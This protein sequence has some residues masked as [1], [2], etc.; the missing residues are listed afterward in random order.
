MKRFFAILLS[1]AMLISASLFV[2]CGDNDSSSGGDNY[3]TGG[4]NGDSSS[5]SSNT[6]TTTLSA[7]TGLTATAAS[8]SQVN[9]YWNSVTDATRYFLYRSEY[10]LS[11]TAS[12]DTVETSSPTTARGLKANTKYYF[13]VQAANDITK[14]EYSSY[15]YATTWAT[16]SSG[17]SGTTTTKLS[18]PTGVNAYY[19]YENGSVT[20]DLVVCVEW[21]SVSG[22]T[23]Y[24]VYKN[25]KASTTYSSLVGTTTSTSITVKGLESGMNYFWVK[26]VNGTT[27][28]DYS[29]SCKIFVM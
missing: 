23:S 14:S 26:A 3:Y 27:S 29:S 18:A 8:S 20:G 19:Q 9:L 2:S 10:P 15:A 28:S 5:G 21:A 7:P 24:K 22:A 17:S 6:T 11:S 4:S 25:T 1:A 12:L 13:W 16:S